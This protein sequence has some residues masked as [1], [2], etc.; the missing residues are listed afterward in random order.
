MQ[1]L[2]WIAQRL[3]HK[4]RNPLSVVMTAASQL[5]GTAG[6]P[7]DDDDIF[8]LRNI[9]EASEQLNEILE[10]FDSFAGNRRLEVD[11]CDINE[12]CTQEIDRGAMSGIVSTG[13]IETDLR[14]DKRVGTVPGDYA[15]L[16]SMVRNVVE[17]ARESIAENGSGT[18][19]MRT[20][21]KDDII[22]I[23]IED[24]GPGVPAADIDAVVCPF[25]TTR[26]GKTGIGLTIAQT[27]ARRHGGDL[28]IHSESGVTRIE[29]TLSDNSEGR[30]RNAVDFDS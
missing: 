1:E 4:L 17:N 8:F 20:T 27:I 19:N 21:R 18:I 30:S 26:S 12:I 29:I 16:Q 7:L 11:F 5:E 28:T 14:L 9:I 3:V 6:E 13:T 24:T 22:W 10:R 23:C 15:L 25:V 2:P